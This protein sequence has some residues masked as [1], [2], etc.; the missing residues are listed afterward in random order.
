MFVIFCIICKM[1]HNNLLVNVMN[2][3]YGG[4]G[5]TVEKRFSS[6]T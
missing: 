2:D 5:N 3:D 1:A 6:I 4:G